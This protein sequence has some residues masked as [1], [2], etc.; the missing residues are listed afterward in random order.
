MKTS[1]KYAG[2]A[3]LVGALSG[4]TGTATQTVNYPSS[5]PV[6]TAPVAPPPAPAAAPTPA[7]QTASP[8]SLPAD[9]A[10]ERALTNAVAA[11]DRGDFGAATRLL[12]PITNDGSL[13]LAQQ[14]RAL[15]TLAFS[16]CS[17]GAVVACRQS[18]ERAFRADSGFDLTTAERGHPIWG[19]QFERA[20]KTV[21]GR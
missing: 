3:F 13:D 9:S 7:P 11:Y 14:L 12:L 8:P 6:A 10:S 15:K 1:V 2:I 16:Q 18:F 20:R 19:P 5:V 4:C 17:T 21:V